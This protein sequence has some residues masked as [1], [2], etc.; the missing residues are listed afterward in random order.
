MEVDLMPA[1]TATRDGIA[2]TSYWQVSGGVITSGPSLAEDV[3]TLSISGIPAGS[4]IQAAYFTATFGSPYS[5]AAEL[6]VNNITV[7]YGQQSVPLTPTADGNGNYTLYFRFRAFGRAQDTDGTHGGTVMVS[8]PTVTVEYTLAEQEEEEEER[9]ETLAANTA[10]QIALFPPDAED[11]TTNGL[12]VLRPFSAEVS[13]TAGGEFALNLQHPMDKE[14]KWALLLEEYLIRSPV[15]EKETPRIVLPAAAVWSVSATSTPL[16][17]VL[18]NYTKAQTPVD[19]IIAN[20]ATWNWRPEDDYPVG[21]Y[22]THDDCIWVAVDDNT[23]VMPGTRPVWDLVLDYGGGATPEPEYIYNPGVVAETLAQGEMITFVADYN[24]TYMQA[25][26]L[27]GVVGYVR[28]A[29]CANTGSETQ[30][31]I[32]ARHI[33]A[34]VFRIKTVTVND[35]IRTV[36]VYA[37]HI[38]YDLGANRLYDCQVTEASPATA[39]A[40]IQGATVHPDSRL[41]ATPMTGPAISQDWSWGNPLSAILD[42]DSGLVHL[43]RAQLIRDDEDF[44]ILPNDAPAQ[45]PALRYGDSLQGVS[46]ERSVD[47]LI[48]RVIP[49]GTD[50]NGGTLLLPEL[51]ID[52]PEISGHPFPYIEFL[53]CDCQVGQTI[54]HADGTE[55]TLTQADCYAIMREKAQ[56]RFSVDRADAV[57]VR[58][59]V[60]PLL[61]G[62]TEEYAQY[63]GLQKLHLYDAVPVIVPHANLSA[64]AQLSGYVWDAAPGRRRFISITLGE[65]FSFGGRTVAGYN[66]AGGAISYDKLAPGL[67]KKIKGM[68]Q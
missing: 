5:G 50:A 48:T 46:W 20:P 62:D 40:V 68:A 2:L 61:L 47:G 67:V 36:S 11:F 10:E 27:R 32:P 39:I 9:Q 17:S 14:G 15:P 7:G 64:T 18:P 35:D 30:T 51:F 56:N 42:P 65:V 59:T 8:N 63:R 19:N 29:D 43:L 57:S 1:K 66:V 6:K 3:F 21:S 60:R 12:A 26:S 22:C 31:V 4:T 13:E 16:Y 24:G 44:F 49:R 34:Q 53:D 41:I 23:G 55:Q 52:S 58:L 33:M 28:R 45:G 37:Q 38:S 54:K 25:R